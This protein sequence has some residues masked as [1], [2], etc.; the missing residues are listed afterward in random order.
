MDTQSKIASIIAALTGAGFTVEQNDDNTLSIESEDSGGLTASLVLGT[1]QIQVSAVLFKAS[2]VNDAAGLNELI[3]RTQQLVP[4]TN[5]SLSR[6]ADGEDYYAAYG[7]LSARSD[8]LQLI[9]EIETLFNNIPEL[10][11]AYSEFYN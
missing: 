1:T 6:Q 8:M 4:L 2:D 10:L 7:S 5:V 11:E 9:E 3:L